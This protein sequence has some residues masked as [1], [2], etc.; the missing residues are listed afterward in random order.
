MVF[1]IAV[2]HAVGAGSSEADRKANFGWL[3]LGFSISNFIGPT[4]AGFMID[5]IGHRATFLVLALSAIGRAL[6]HRLEAPRLRRQPRH[7]EG[8]PTRA[9]PCSCCASRS[10]GACSW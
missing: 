8:A 5:L 7:G 1:H 2:Q 10:C 9:M 4:S 6:A 3:A